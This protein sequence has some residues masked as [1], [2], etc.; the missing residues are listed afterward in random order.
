M[1]FS[2]L[3]FAVA[4]L[5][6]DVQPL[7]TWTLYNSTIT[8]DLKTCQYSFFTHKHR[9]G[10]TVQ[11]YLNMRGTPSSTTLFVDQICQPD[12]LHTLTLSWA[13]DHS[14]ILC[15]ADIHERANAFYSLERWEVADN[16]IAPNKTE[17]AWRAGEVPLPSTTF[18]RPAPTLQ[19]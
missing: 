8:C 9:S 7:D 10:E 6:Q 16:R 3:A 2:I 5:G 19:E 18:T 1:R 17:F 14:V 11:C 15:I 4:V 13:P 12:P